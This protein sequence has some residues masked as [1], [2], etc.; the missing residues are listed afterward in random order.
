[1]NP[2][3][4]H[5]QGE[6]KMQDRARNPQPKRQRRSGFEIA[7][8]QQQQG[9]GNGGDEVDLDRMAHFQLDRRRMTHGLQA[10]KH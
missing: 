5:A 3:A 4:E 1:M 8:R 9:N 2:T 6:P 7:D 10:I